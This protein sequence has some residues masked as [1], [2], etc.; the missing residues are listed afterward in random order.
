[1]LLNSCTV[2]LVFTFITCF[3]DNFFQNFWSVLRHSFY[4][5]LGSGEIKIYLKAVIFFYQFITYFCMRRHRQQTHQ[6]T[7]LN[8]TYLCIHRHRQQTPQSTFFNEVFITYLSMRGL[9]GLRKMTKCRSLSSIF[10]D[11]F[12]AYLC[13]IFVCEKLSQNLPLYISRFFCCKS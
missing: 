6:S 9:F 4:L 5:A 8:D 1:M 11:A 7:F 12:I 13:M 10:Y 3:P 2:L